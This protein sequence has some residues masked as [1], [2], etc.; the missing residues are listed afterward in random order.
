FM[1]SVLCETPIIES[2]V[3]HYFT[4]NNLESVDLLKTK[5]ISEYLRLDYDN[6]KYLQ[7][8]ILATP[9]FTESRKKIMANNRV[10]AVDRLADEYKNAA[11]LTTKQD[12]NPNSGIIKFDKEVIKAGGQYRNLTP[13]ECFLLMGFKENDF[14]TL[15]ENDLE[16]LSGKKF[17]SNARLYKLTGNSIVVP[18][19]EEIFKQIDYINSEILA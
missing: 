11:T 4:L 3:D 16:I 1:I 10:L 7:E 12:R 17:L 5:N 19:L 6:N 2:N 13:R 15:V 8:A 14:D 18:V 9:N